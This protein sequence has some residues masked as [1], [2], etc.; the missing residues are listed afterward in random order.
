MKTINN[1]VNFA[2]RRETLQSECFDIL[3]SIVEN[4]VHIGG[5]DYRIN[6]KYFDK[7]KKYIERITD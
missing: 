1:Q 7:A 5:G 4:S 2:N 3:K 6:E